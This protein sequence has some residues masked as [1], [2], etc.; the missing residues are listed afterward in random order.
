MIQI[1]HTDNI[2]PT[3]MSKVLQMA[4]VQ[5]SSKTFEWTRGK[6]GSI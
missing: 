4:A 3:L 2:G 1:G 5:N 6:T